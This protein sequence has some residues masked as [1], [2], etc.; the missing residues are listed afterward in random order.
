ME[1]ATGEEPRLWGSIVGFGDY[2][3]RY[4]SGREGDWFLAGF[5]PRKQNLSLYIMAGFD[6]YDELLSRLGKYKTGKACL[7]INKVEDVDL[8]V[9]EELV[10][11]SAEHMRATNPP[12]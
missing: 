4:E 1:K 12:A 10:R 7:Y 11:R 8:E 2:H 9:L 3:Y 5:A 6:K